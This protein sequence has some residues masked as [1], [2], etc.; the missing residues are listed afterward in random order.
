MTIDDMPGGAKPAG[1]RCPHVTHRPS[2]PVLGGSCGAYETRPPS[3]RAF[4][5]LWL[6]GNFSGAERP[7]RTG[8]VLW[9]P[10]PDDPLTAAG[11]SIVA[12]KEARAGALAGP[13]N[14]VL[15]RSLEQQGHTVMR[16]RLGSEHAT[17]EALADELRPARRNPA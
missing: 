9:R 17:A 13:A 10:G 3:C 5:C 6:L 8:L 1:E 16:A 12:A 11:V 14:R 4:R 2:L 7:D 15:L